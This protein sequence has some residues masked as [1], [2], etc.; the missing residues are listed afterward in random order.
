MITNK[1]FR[2]ALQE[3]AGVTIFGNRFNTDRSACLNEMRRFVSE[4]IPIKVGD[5]SYRFNDGSVIIEMLDG[6]SC[7]SIDNLADLTA[8]LFKLK[9]VA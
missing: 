3:F 7:E 9:K 6:G 1:M 4:N 2:H 5:L 8:Y